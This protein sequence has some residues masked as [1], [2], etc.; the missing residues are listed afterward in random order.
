MSPGKYY[1]K[2]IMRQIAKSK[3]ILLLDSFLQRHIKTTLK[4]RS[5]HPCRHKVSSHT[6][7]M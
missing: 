1:D 3:T 5:K 4:A 6:E 7:L 2:H